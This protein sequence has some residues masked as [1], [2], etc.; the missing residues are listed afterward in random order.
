MRQYDRD[1]DQGYSH[2]KCVELKR[3]LLPWLPTDPFESESL[4]YTVS[5]LGLA[6]FS[7]PRLFSSTFFVDLPAVPWRR[8]GGVGPGQSAAGGFCGGGARGGAAGLLSAP[9]G[10]GGGE[11]GHAAL[12]AAGFSCGLHGLGGG[13]G[14]EVSAGTEVGAGVAVGV[15]VGAGVGVKVRAGVCFAVAGSH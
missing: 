10:G 6:H 5:L 12:M 1:L 4:D 7:V 2:N 9:A 11:T 14:A 3:L 13:S 8:F 15:G